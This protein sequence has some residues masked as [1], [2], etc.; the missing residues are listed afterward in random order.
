MPNLTKVFISFF[1]IKNIAC[2]A[3]LFP[4]PVRLQYL[5]CSTLRTGSMCKKSVM[6]SS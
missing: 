1:L 3:F 5:I 2:I 6:M 4:G